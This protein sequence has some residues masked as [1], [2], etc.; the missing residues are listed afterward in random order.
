[1][2]TIGF[3]IR[4]EFQQLRR[5]RRLL[6][7]IFL[8]PVIQIAL[9]GYAANMDVK[10]IPLA[11]CDQDHTVESRQLAA[12]FLESGSYVASAYVPDAKSAER[13]IEEGKSSLALVIPPRIRK[14][15]GGDK[16]GAAS[17]PGGRLRH[18]V[19]GNRADICNPYCLP[20]TERTRR[21]K[22]GGS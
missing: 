5:D 4:K 15:V 16:D 7:L 6:P 11:V 17:A 2:R 14:A 8:S 1:M 22:A 18:A 19:R 21:A 20:G 12:S 13:S 10:D 3:I 9:L